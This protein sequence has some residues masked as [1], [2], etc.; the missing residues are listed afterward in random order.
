MCPNYKTEKAVFIATNAASDMLRQKE[1]PTRSRR[2]VVFKDQLRYRRSLFKGVVY[3]KFLVRE[4]LF[5]VN[6]GSIARNFPK[7]RTS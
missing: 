1:R 2:K 6:M 4:N 3:L 7:V 5:Y